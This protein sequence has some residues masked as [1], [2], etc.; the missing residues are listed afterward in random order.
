MSQG[1]PLHALVGLG[2]PGPEYAGTRHNAGFLFL[3]LVANQAGA[4]FRREARFQADVARASIAGREV[5]LLAPQTF[6]NHSGDAVAKF[7]HYYKIAPAEILVVHDELDLSPGVVRVKFGGGAG[8]HN[9]LS[10]IIEKLGTPDF[11]RLRIGIGHPA[12][13]G[14]VAGY[15]LRRAPAAEATLIENSMRPALEQLPAILR[16]DLSKVM[17]VLHRSSPGENGKG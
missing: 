10:D 16:G 6:M 15:V 8:G 1:S 12:R 14:D 5:Y 3:D 9:G 7:A 11:A 17:N 2:N 4:G 13:G